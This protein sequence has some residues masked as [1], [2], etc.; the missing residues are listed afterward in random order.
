MRELVH[1][2]TLSTYPV[3]RECTLMYVEGSGQ[4][5][6]GKGVRDD[7]EESRDRAGTLCEDKEDATQRFRR[8]DFKLNTRNGR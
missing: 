3:T 1:P 6:E 7:L 5:K 2:G 8:A 4:S